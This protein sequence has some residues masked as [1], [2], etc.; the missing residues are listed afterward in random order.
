MKSRWLHIALAPSHPA[1]ACSPAL[2]SPT[3][4]S[5]LFVVGCSL[6]AACNGENNADDSSSL[7]PTPDSG[8]VAEGTADAGGA[9]EE[10]GEPQTF[11]GPLGPYF[12]EIDVGYDALLETFV[13]HARFFC[14]CETGHNS[15]DEY[16]ACVDGY[17]APQ[18]PP[19]LACTKTVLSRSAS[20]LES[21]H[22]ELENAET[23]IA[24][25][26]EST[27][28]D[29]THITGCETDRI[30]SGLDCKD[31]PYDVWAEERTLCYGWEVP[32]GFE[33]ADGEVVDPT[34]ECDF[35]EDCADGSDETDCPD[36]H[37]GLDL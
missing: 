20:A 16:D 18:P 31:V 15:G 12:E 35:T 23:Y 26:R 14:V 32:P 27:C 19:L 33:C 25:I 11:G 37:A 8:S 17:N 13:D 10:P 22:C 5:C 2:Q 3:V 9:N 7:Q 30:I 1:K 34:Y 29:F 36:P 6:A 4:L 21:L 24:C 28:I